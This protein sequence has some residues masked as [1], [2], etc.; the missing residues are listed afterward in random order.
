[1]NYTLTAEEYILSLLLLDGAEVAHSIKEEVFG[2]ISEK[3][4]ETRLD[5][6]TSGLISKGL[7]TF[8]N[9]QERMDETFK[10]FMLG[11]TKVKRVIRC[12]IASDDGV[13]S[14]SLF[15]HNSFFIQ[16]A[17]YDNRIYHLYEKS[18]HTD[19]PALIDLNP[20]VESGESFSI[21]EQL[22]ERVIDKLLGNE[23]LANEEIEQFSP[24]FFK[25]LQEKK[26]KLNALYDYHLGQQ[27]SI[28]SL[29][30]ITYEEESWSIENKG[31]TLIISPFSFQD[32]LEV[33]K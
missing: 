5:S 19:L 21:K 3:E 6:A 28:G 17:L 12:Q 7:L 8:E 16:N 26:G 23:E 24:V 27:V 30:Y 4:L 15:C 10:S 13:F 31:D 33:E 9:Q 11:L 22:F 2:E 18:D 20:Y 14:T 29:L 25:A 32:L 1:M